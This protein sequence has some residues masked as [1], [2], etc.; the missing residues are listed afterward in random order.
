MVYKRSKP[1]DEANA[2]LAKKIA[3]AI[4]ASGL[5]GKE[6]AERCGVSPQA[7]I[8]WKK[9]GTISKKLLP[10][11]AN[12]VKVPLAHFM[13]AIPSSPEDK[14]L[15]STENDAHY[16]D[17]DKLI[18]LIQ[19]YKDSTVVGREFILNAALRAEKR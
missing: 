5:K 14:L 17:G 13:P 1:K 16:L 3:Y 19:L 18:A 2:E 15:A 8:G 12:V 10:V 6:V 9:T 4:Q 7:V 11:F